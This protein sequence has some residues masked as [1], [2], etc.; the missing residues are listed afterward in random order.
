MVI[1]EIECGNGKGLNYLNRVYKPKFCVGLDYSE[2][3]VIFL[4]YIQKT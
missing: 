1:L 4:L 3:N 2:E